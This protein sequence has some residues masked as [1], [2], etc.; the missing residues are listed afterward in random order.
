[1]AELNQYFKG[2]DIGI[3]ITGDST[4]DVS[5]AY[6]GNVT[7]TLMIYPNNLDLS[8]ED[9]RAKV[10]EVKS[11]DRQMAPENDHTYVVFSEDHNSVECIIPW[12]ITKTLDAGDYTVELVWGSGYGRVIFRQNSMLT[13][14][15]SGG[16]Y[17][18]NDMDFNDTDINE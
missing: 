5:E 3:E 11:T 4:F 17:V 14:V 15:D 13:V 2:E 8:I 12:K 16:E 18:N 10:V 6:A 9:N 1:M 7:F